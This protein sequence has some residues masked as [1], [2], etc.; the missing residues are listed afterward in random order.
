[1]LVLLFTALPLRQD[2]TCM[3]I[4]LYGECADG[5][6]AA[7][8]AKA[9]NVDPDLYRFLKTLESYE[10]T[11]DEQSWLVLGTDADYAQLLRSMVPPKP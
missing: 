9:Y 10:K 2:Q 7:I 5:E 3:V 11:V 6:A 8:Y 4:T 1:M